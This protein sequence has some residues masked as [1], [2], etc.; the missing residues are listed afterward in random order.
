M[1]ALKKENG[2]TQFKGPE[3][4]QRDKIKRKEMSE[5]KCK[6]MQFFEMRCSYMSSLKTQA[7]RCEFLE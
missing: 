3:G 4:K 5:I 1:V 2:K 6:R 7:S